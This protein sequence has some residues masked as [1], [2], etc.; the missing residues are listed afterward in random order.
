MTSEAKDLIEEM[1]TLD[2]NKRISAK[3]AYNHQWIQ[4]NAPKPLVPKEKIN[5][6]LEH[7]EKFHVIGY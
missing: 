3:E 4:S 6:M 2:P 7:I 5:T 1:L